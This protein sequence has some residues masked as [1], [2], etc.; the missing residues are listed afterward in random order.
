ML[1]PGT[2]STGL[3]RPPSLSACLALRTVPSVPVSS[4]EAAE[5]ETV[6]RSQSL[7]RDQYGVE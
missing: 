4:E 7:T 2:R 6:S 1:G 3:R 5:I